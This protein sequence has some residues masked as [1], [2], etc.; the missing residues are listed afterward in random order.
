MS[1]VTD[2][3][4]LLYAVNEDSEFHQ[5]SKA[6]IEKCAESTEPWCMPWPVINAFIRI[7]THP[8]ILSR[9]LSSSHALVIVNQI[10]ELPHV[11][12]AGEESPE[13]WK[14]FS[15]D[16]GS[17]HLRGNAITDAHIVAIMRTNG[18]S[19]IY[20]KDTDFLRFAG[21]KVIDPVGK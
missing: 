3:N 13:F 20:S 8:A 11:T 6:F 4:L 12:T 7:S 21:I 9:P 14:L 17:H 18:V 19:V 10:L 15:R 2:T 5:K 16:I 1:F